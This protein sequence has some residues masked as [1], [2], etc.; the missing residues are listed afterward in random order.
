MLNRDELGALVRIIAGRRLTDLDVSLV[1]SEADR[2]ESNTITVAEF[3][4]TLQELQEDDILSG[5][6]GLD[7]LAS[8][9]QRLATG[10]RSGAVRPQPV[11]WRVRVCAAVVVLRVG[12]GC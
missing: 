8:A 11:N 12:H 1:V 3:A 2:N 10:I 9:C 4:H 5:V 7:T 6:L